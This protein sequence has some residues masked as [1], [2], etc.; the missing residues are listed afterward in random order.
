MVNNED[1]RDDNRT[2]LEELDAAVNTALS[3]T[4]GD[5]RQYD[6]H[7]LVAFVL[8]MGFERYNKAAYISLPSSSS[9]DRRAGPFFQREA[10]ILRDMTSYLPISPALS[11]IRQ[12][13]SKTYEY[14]R[15]REST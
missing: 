4:G 15:Y 8:S 6:P 14:L 2:G 5:S 9:S 13:A 3:I 10:L 11:C 7:C 12:R 1:R